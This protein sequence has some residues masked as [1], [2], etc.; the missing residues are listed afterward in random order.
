MFWVLLGLFGSV[1]SY[2]LVT[3]KE[4]FLLTGSVVIGVSLGDTLY[5]WSIREIGSS[6]TMAIVG[7]VPL[8]TLVFEHY[9][10]GQPFPARF[11]AGCFFVDAGVACK[12]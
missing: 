10:L 1:D 4:W 5:L 3:L 8:P 2:W 11:V 6:R 12:P 9:L 7:I